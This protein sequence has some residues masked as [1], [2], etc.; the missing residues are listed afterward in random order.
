MLSDPEPQ[1]PSPGLADEVRAIDA[2]LVEDRYCICDA[3]RHLVS[4]RVVRLV[5]PAQ[6]AVVELDEPEL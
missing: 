3:R 2:E 5:A 4:V 1:P 6:P